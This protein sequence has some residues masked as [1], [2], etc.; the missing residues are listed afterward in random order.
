MCLSLCISVPLRMCIYDRVCVCLCK[1]V[2]SAVAQRGVKAV[3]S[4]GGEEE[5]VGV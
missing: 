1:Y 5:Y 2:L 4:S 3:K